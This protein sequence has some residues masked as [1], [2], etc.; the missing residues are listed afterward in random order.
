M[1]QA[2]GQKAS[3]LGEEYFSKPTPMLRS[4]NAQTLNFLKSEERLY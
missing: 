1:F 2:V 4:L 3:S